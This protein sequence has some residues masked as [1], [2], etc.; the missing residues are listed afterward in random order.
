MSKII[1]LLVFALCFTGCAYK[2]PYSSSKSYF[3]VLK[4][5]QIALADTGFIK[6]DDSRLN[7]QLF[8]AGVPIFD[9]HVNQNICIDYVC[10]KREIFNTK[11]FGYRHYKQFIDDLFHMQPLY[12]KKNL[13]KTQDGFEQTLKTD[14]YDIS[15]KINNNNLYFKDR[16]NNIL[17]KLK[18]L[19]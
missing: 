11:F 16:K 10:L 17:I 13:I 18:E 1:G 5:T 19:R 3:I 2:I 9:L 12:D 6:Q 4:N 7:L 15:Y 14:N 8:S